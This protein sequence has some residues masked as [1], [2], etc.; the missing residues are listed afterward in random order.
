[1]T[2]VDD[3]DLTSGRLLLAEYEQIKEEQRGR[4]GFRDNLLYVTLAST[5]AVVLAA[6]Q[7]PGRPALLLLLPPVTFVLGWTYLVNDQK[8]SAIGSYIRTE[9]APRLAA[10]TPER[11]PVFGWEIAH[12]SDHRRVSRKVIQLAVD[13]VLFCASALVAIGI[14]WSHGYQDGLLSAVSLLEIIVTAVLAIQILLYADIR[15]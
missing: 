4:I 12:R 2:P 1:M 14:Y 6:L 11:L 5:A 8:I 13:L 7:D 9:L 10:L 15:R 3:S